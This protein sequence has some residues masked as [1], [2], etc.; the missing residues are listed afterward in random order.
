MI[1]SMLSSDIFTY[2]YI[3]IHKGIKHVCHQ[4]SD[5][6]IQFKKSLNVKIMI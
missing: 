6:E 5:V 2:I 4:L 1:F 3:T